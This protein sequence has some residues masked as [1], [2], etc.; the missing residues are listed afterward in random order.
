MSHSVMTEFWRGLRARVVLSVNAPKDTD[1][2]YE[3]KTTPSNRGKDGSFT[4]LV[5]SPRMYLKVQP[6][7]GLEQNYLKVSIPIGQIQMFE[8]QLRKV[9]N[10]INEHPEIY[11]TDEYGVLHLDHAAAKKYA[12]GLSV[13]T[14]KIL[15][16]PSVV[17][18]VTKSVKGILIT[19]M[20]QGGVA[21]ISLT[22][23]RDLITRLEVIDPFTIQIL[24]AIADNSYRTNVRL[25]RMEIKINEMLGL[26]RGKYSNQ[27]QTKSDN[28]LGNPTRIRKDEF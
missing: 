11:T 18:D 5:F 26:L 19:N 9:Y 6:C 10:A 13:F 28:G 20:N 14:D 1:D 27:N 8:L 15:I 4:T 17:Q 21:T 2:F 25:E 24:L 7:G 22:E 12:K 23:L 3:K 16:I